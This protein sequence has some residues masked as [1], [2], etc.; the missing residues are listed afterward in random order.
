PTAHELIC[1][2]DWSPWNALFRNGRLAL[3]LDWD[4]AGPGSKIW[5]IANA[6]HSW[7][8]LSVEH[9][10]SG[11]GTKARRMRLFLDGYGLDDRTAVLPTM[12]LRLQH[13]GGFIDDQARLGDVGMQRLVSWNVPKKMFED[14]VRYLDEHWGLLERAL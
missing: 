10:K 1:H 9:T 2:N 8:P 5:D 6:V 14:D 13:V 3:T 11:I 4:L 7:A 12:R